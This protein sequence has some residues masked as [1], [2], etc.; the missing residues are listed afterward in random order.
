MFENPFCEPMTSFL[1][2][3]VDVGDVGDV[4]TDSVVRLFVDC[5]Q[6]KSRGSNLIF[7]D[8]SLSLGPSGSTYFSSIGLAVWSLS[9]IAS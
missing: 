5:R 4:C 9:A 6:T 8:V 7:C 3:I 1:C 2:D